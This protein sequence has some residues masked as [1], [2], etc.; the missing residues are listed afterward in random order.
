MLK[1][2]RV[3]LSTTSRHAVPCPLLNRSLSDTAFWQVLC[4]QGFLAARKHAEQIL[5]LAEM[6]QVRWT[7]LAFPLPR[8]T[9]GSLKPSPAHRPELERTVLPRRRESDSAAS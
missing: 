3:T 7:A 2:A 6:M 4:I 9:V 5:L 8:S 1:V